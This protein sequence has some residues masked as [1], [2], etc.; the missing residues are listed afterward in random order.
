MSD[1]PWVELRVTD[2]GSGITAE[3]MERIFDPFFSTKAPGRGSGM[4]LAMVHGI[5]HDHGGHLDVNTVPGRGSTFALRLPVA[6]GHS[7][8]DAPALA[9]DPHSTSDLQGRVLLVEDD[10]MVG[11]FLAERLRSWGLEVVLQREPQRAAEW[12]LDPANEAAL[13]LTD[14]TMPQMTG[15]ELAARA[16]IARPRLPIV[17]VSGNACAF[18]PDELTRCGVRIALPKPLDS[19]R[20]R[21]VLR[22]LLGSP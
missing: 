16:R 20:L 19:E 2:S 18:D 5:V 12:L 1:G 13:L 9:I 17:L 15:L 8:K 7:A 14:Q 11:E 3:L 21:A 22:K 6:E 10:Q 4:G